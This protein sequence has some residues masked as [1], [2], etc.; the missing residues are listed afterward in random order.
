M[1]AMRRWSVVFALLGACAQTEV[2]PEALPPDTMEG[3]TGTPPPPSVTLE[4]PTPPRFFVATASLEVLRRHTAAF[5]A[6]PPR[7]LSPRRG[8]G[9][10]R[11]EGRVVFFGT[12]PSEHLAIVEFL[13]VDSTRPASLFAISTSGIE[14]DAPVAIAHGIHSLRAVHLTDRMAV[15]VTD[16]GLYAVALDGSDADEPRVLQTTDGLS[17]I[18]DAAIG[19]PYVAYEYAS[20]PGGEPTI[21]VARWDDEAPEPSQI[22]ARFATG[23]VL[24]A[25]ADG[26]FFVNVEE[27]FGLFAPAEGP[28][29]TQIIWGEVDVIDV[30]DSEPLAV[31]KR[32]TRELGVIDFS[33][34]NPVFRILILPT[35][36]TAFG[37]SSDH[38]QMYAIGFDGS[39]PGLYHAPTN[40][41]L[42]AQPILELPY[43]ARVSE[44][45][46]SSDGRFAVLCDGSRLLRASPTE[47]LTEI[48]STA[49]REMQPRAVVG[50]DRVVMLSGGDTMRLVSL[51]DGHT[52]DLRGL[53]TLHKLLKDGFLT[54][55]TTEPES[56]I[57]RMDQPERVQRLLPWRSP[58]ISTVHRIDE[59]LLYARDGRWFLLPLDGG[60]E[61]PLADW[62]E[63]EL[64]GVTAGHLLLQAGFDVRSYPLDASASGEPVLRVRRPLPAV[65]HGVA[66]GQV[67]WVLPDGLASARVDGSEA[68]DYVF[69]SPYPIE[70]ARYDAVSKRLVL[71]GVYNQSIDVTTIGLDGSEVTTI[72]DGPRARI[73]GWPTFVDL[74]PGASRI[75]LTINPP[76]TGGAPFPP[77]LWSVEIGGTGSI[78]EVTDDGQTLWRGPQAP[79]LSNGTRAVIVDTT[80]TF[81]ASLTAHTYSSI[82]TRSLQQI[83]PATISR[84]DR[85]LLGHS[86][87]GLFAVRTDGAGQV[88][89]VAP[90]AF[91]ARFTPDNLI[92]YAAHGREGADSALFVR[93]V[94]EDDE[95]RR[96]T[97]SGFRVAALYESDED[98]SLVA[99]LSGGDWSVFWV[100]HDDHRPVAV[101]P[102]DDARETPIA[103]LTVY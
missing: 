70:H 102:L 34:A 9:Y 64:F 90:D 60:A 51:D 77:S 3:P 75:L 101:T 8:Q 65:E 67:Y 44:L 47:G 7:R 15:Y 56:T 91:A 45:A 61:R 36:L 14:P 33:G 2:P 42:R 37:V 66:D 72:V 52:E 62:P 4:E 18:G 13:P 74:V 95:S 6:P 79:F 49:C 94:R 92:V 26:R 27:G 53:P 39:I 48:S 81:V 96:V 46:V 24:G 63:S 99:S 19:G 97:P 87:D 40:A 32:G 23:R 80:A 103:P 38:R 25:L 20:R 29:V 88:I 58:A 10:G 28:R 31:V 1:E 69:W 83:G 98:G 17:W 84:D 11:G 71:V 21:R 59:G 43:D 76:G 86:S 93:S 16:S 100:A 35:S 89:S 73:V 5:G 22:D 55:T 50:G 68:L 54:F 41:R 12:T 30:L 85:W 57:Y 78:V 82:V